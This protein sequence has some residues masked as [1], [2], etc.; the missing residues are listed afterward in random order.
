MKIVVAGGTGFIGQALCRALSK[1]GD[2]V[3]ALGR[4]AGATALAA[5]EG[6]RVLAWTAA[7]GANEPWQAQVE[8]ADALVNLAGEPVVGRRWTEGQKRRIRASRL[9]AVA[10]LTEAVERAEV[11]PSVC[12]SASAVGYYGVRDA[13]PIDESAPAGEDF[14]ARVCRDWEEATKSIE[15]LGTRVV[16]PRIGL[17]LGQGG[18]ALSKLAT[19]FRLGVGGPMGTG[20]Q[21]VPWIH[22]DDVVGLILKA[23][24]DRSFVGPVNAV[25]PGGVDNE[26]FSKALGRVLH[27]PTFVRTPGF[28]VRFALGEAADVVLGGQH[29]TADKAMDLGYAFKW[30]VLEDALTSLLVVNG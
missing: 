20:R 5:L 19:P 12:V 6:V 13:S 7:P 26:A 1:R 25:S 14:L 8:G 29:P 4:H 16:L 18:G 24:D 23:I 21:W 30:P 15:A 28:A 3:V 10:A 2:E 17:V 27:R 9:E 22:L 11:R